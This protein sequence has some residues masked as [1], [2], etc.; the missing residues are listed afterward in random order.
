MQPDEPLNWQLAKYSGLF[1]D[2]LSAEES[3]PI[4]EVK[5]PGNKKKHWYN[6]QRIV[7]LTFTADN[8]AQCSYSRLDSWILT[9]KVVILL[10]ITTGENGRCTRLRRKSWRMVYIFDGI[11][12]ER[13][14]SS[15][16]LFYQRARIRSPAGCSSWFAAILG[17]C[18]I[19]RSAFCR[20]A[21]ATMAIALLCSL[22]ERAVINFSPHLSQRCHEGK[23]S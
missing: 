22:E 18:L 1:A 9:S 7:Q 10:D 5:W 3:N 13:S 19:V 23:W 8:W 4:C 11:C 21:L 6:A 12:E 15:R 17:F 2:R 20:F 16:L 14:S